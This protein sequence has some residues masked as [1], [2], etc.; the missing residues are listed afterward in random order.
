MPTRRKFLKNSLTTGAYIGLGL[1]GMRLASAQDTTDE[2]ALNKA[3]VRRFKESQGTD[4]YEQVLA[5]V[6]SPDYRRL[7]PDSRTWQRTRPDPNWRRQPN[8]CE[9]HFQTIPIPLIS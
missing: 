8:P 9:R 1:P 4:E 2:E 7:R 6:Q 5:E 3:V